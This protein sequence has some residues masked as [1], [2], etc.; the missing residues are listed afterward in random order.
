MLSIFILVC[1]FLCIPI[2]AEQKQ[3]VVFVPSYNNIKFYK[4]NLDSIVAQNYSNY[5]VVYIDDCSTDGTG[6]AVAEY[7]RERN[8]EEKILLICNP[9]RRGAM[10]NHYVLG[11]ALPDHVIMATLDGDDWFPDHN[12]Q[13][14]ARVNQEY[15]NPEVLMTFGQ[16][17]EYPSGNKGFCK[18]LPE[19]ICLLHAYRDFGWYT[20]HLRTYYAGL[21]KHIPVGYFIRDDTFLKT[22]C[23]LAIMFA[24]L[25]LSGG[26]VRFIDEILYTY[27]TTNDNSDHRTRFLEQIHNDHW[28]R[29]CQPLQ[30]LTYHPA[31]RTK[32]GSMR[33]VVWNLHLSCNGTEAC[34]DYCTTLSI[35]GIYTKNVQIFYEPLLQK[36]SIAYTSLANDFGVTVVAVDKAVACKEAVLA[37][38]DTLSAESYVLLTIDGCKWQSSCNLID[39]MRIMIKTKAICYSGTSGLDTTKDS[40]LAAEDTLPSMVH[41]YD[42]YYVWKP[43]YAQGAWHHPYASPAILINVASLKSQIDRIQGATIQQLLHNLAQLAVDNSNDVVLCTATA[44]CFYKDVS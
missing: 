34:R 37:Y 43:A 29:T 2:Y 41:T 8:L 5:Y 17:E 30:P 31:Q 42:E 40:I 36:D 32:N 9:Q 23:D 26:R 21:F 12:Q 1:S 6:R 39:A 11:N 27:N 14:L 10:Y 22:T 3:I 13:V 25:E 15:Q 33:T 28:I 24:L 44:P 7:I 4:K 38:L 20:S 16:F 35:A 19:T 18:A